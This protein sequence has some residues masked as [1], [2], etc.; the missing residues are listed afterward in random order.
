MGFIW[1]LGATGLQPVDFAYHHDVFAFTKWYTSECI[2]SQSQL[3][4]AMWVQHVGA[5]DHRLDA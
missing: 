1:L 5:A 4:G 2:I 3:I